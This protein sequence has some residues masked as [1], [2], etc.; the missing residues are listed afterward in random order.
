MCS[1]LLN[2]M[3]IGCWVVAN[4]SAILNTLVAA[5]LL[6]TIK[7]S[8]L[9]KIIS[10]KSISFENFREPPVGRLHPGLG[11]STQPLL[12][13]LVCAHL[14]A[15]R[16]PKGAHFP[17]LRAVHRFA[18]RLEFCGGEKSS[19]TAQEHHRLFVGFLLHFSNFIVKLFSASLCPT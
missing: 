5:S 8:K 14:R 4:L 13:G 15:I 9:Y 7:R 16:R 6:F 18:V 19:R 12:C 2:P 10:K 17:L 3:T 1:Y 11:H